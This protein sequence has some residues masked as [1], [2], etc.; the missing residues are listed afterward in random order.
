[1]CHKLPSIWNKLLSGCLGC[2]GAG[3][4]RLPSQRETWGPGSAGGEG[5]LQDHGDALWPL[6]PV[7]GSSLP[8][9]KLGSKP[10]HY[11]RR[12]QGFAESVEN[13]GFGGGEALTVDAVN[14]SH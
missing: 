8:L 14:S 1:M 9:G 4:K 7:V 13:C 10:T 5:D 2:R 12:E 3:E 6:C 11:Q